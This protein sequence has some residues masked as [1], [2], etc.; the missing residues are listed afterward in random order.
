MYA[1][2]IQEGV[3][4]LTLICFSSMAS[5]RCLYSSGKCSSKKWSNS[6]HTFGN[7]LGCGLWQTWHLSVSSSV[8]VTQVWQYTGG[9]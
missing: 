3:S 6:K 5:L 1:I 7:L 8:L 4:S 2:Y 9:I